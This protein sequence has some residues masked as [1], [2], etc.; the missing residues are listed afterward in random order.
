[1]TRFGRYFFLLFAAL[2]SA[3][4]AL[5]EIAATTEVG[6]VNDAVVTA[7]EYVEALRRL[8]FRQQPIP[9]LR[10]AAWDECVRFKLVQFFARELGRID[11][12]SDAALRQAWG[13]ENARRT[14]ALD[15]KQVVFGPKLLT[16]E[17]FRA[18]WADVIERDYGKR[19]LN[20]G[21]IKAADARDEFAAFAA[22]LRRAR[23][24]AKTTVQTDRLAQ[25]DAMTVLAE[26]RPRT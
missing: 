20:S 2:V 26:E 5:A 6:R 24:M 22:A 17:Q 19:V 7:R 15:S 12:V 16:W 25:L 8:R 4:P 9:E 23:E 14:S 13:R 11:D 1:M 18:T 10:L 3:S 21:Q